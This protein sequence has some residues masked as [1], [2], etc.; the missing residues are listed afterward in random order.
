MDKSKL[1]ESDLTPATN[2]KLVTVQ[3]FHWL[4]N[5]QEL[6]IVYYDIEGF[7]ET[8]IFLTDDFNNWIAVRPLRFSESEQKYQIEQYLIHR[9]NLR[10]VAEVER[11]K[12]VIE[13]MKR[14]AEQALNELNKN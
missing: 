6:A 14:E 11:L 5:H 3:S 1:S 8:V 2:K 4:N 13:N 10:D 12:R 9:L 7:S